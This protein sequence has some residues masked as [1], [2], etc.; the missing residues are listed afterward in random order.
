MSLEDAYAHLRA[1]R[2]AE[3]EAELRRVVGGRAGQAEALELLGIVLSQQGR[4]YEALEYFDRAIVV[5]PEAPGARHNRAQALFALG[6]VAEARAE[7]DAVVSAQPDLHAAW[8][9]LG[10]VLAAQGDSKAEQAYRRALMLRPD[11]PETHY[12]LGVFF[13]DTGRLDEAIACN[14]KAIALR[15]NFVAAHNNLANAL[16]A[17]GRLEEALTHYGQAVRLEPRFA[18]GWSNYGVAL[19]EAGRVE[20]AIPALERAVGL[21]PHAWSAISNLGVAYLARNRFEEAVAC[22]RKALE[23]KPDSAEVLSHLG[24]ALAGTARWEEAE[25]CYRQAIQK[26]PAYAEAHNNLGTLRMERGDVAGA[27]ASF[28]NALELR[29]GYADATN[30]MG[31]LLQEEG[32]IDEAI[33]IY[34]R[35]RAA[36]P[37]NARAGYNLGIVLVSRFEFTEGWELCEL[38]CDTVP[39]V[40]PRRPF[41]V[42]RLEREPRAG[43]RIAVWREQGV[44]DQILYSTLLPELAQRAAG[45]VVE[46]DRRLV[47]AFRRAHSDWTVVAPEESAAAFSGCDA[48]IPLGSLPR[49]FRPSLA[50]FAAQPRAL[51]AADPGRAR[52]FREELDRT[53]AAPKPPPLVGISWRSFQPSV[54]G[55]LG[56]RKSATLASFLGLSPGARLLDLQY[57]D[58]D[59]E[60]E[61]FARAGGRLARLEGLDLFNDL[62]G[63]IAAIE[64]CD[65]VVTTSNL[66]AHLAGSIGKRTLLVFLNARPPFHY[67]SSP[68]ERSLWYPSV[69]IVTAPGLDTWERALAR[70]HE[71]LY[72]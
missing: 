58:T 20:E 55:E 56:K 37:R 40:T 19:R 50:S 4:A 59:A 33:E 47:P 28:R 9:L 18:D 62:D 38:R 30:N 8:N 32:R 1:G 25:A 39:P 13:L 11:H 12:N 52:A 14:R 72:G 10:S 53:V 21:A 24:N 46:V 69:E 44:G 41:A 17:R 57:G 34:R 49:L 2:L 42:P 36:D 7:L 64:A 31:F 61:E 35:A 15:A 67:W 66:T 3:A 22:Q 51:L 5:R 23:L 27:A 26:A 6:R 54:R 45:F 71:I 60:R 43:E 48:H 63:L 16:R 29:P 65:V 70:V 68:D